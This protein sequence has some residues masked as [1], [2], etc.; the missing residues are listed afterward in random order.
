MGIINYV[1]HNTGIHVSYHQCGASWN[2]CLLSSSQEQKERKEEQKK[3]SVAIKPH[4]HWLREIKGAGT[5]QQIMHY[6]VPAIV[7]LFSF[8]FCQRFKACLGAGVVV[9]SEIKIMFLAIFPDPIIKRLLH[10]S[11][12]LVKLCNVWRANV[13]FHLLIA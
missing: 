11:A 2:T 8:G 4:P 6:I 5:M 3:K 1:V 10:C 9:V 7:W 12:F 13:F